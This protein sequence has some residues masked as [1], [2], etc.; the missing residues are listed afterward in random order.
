MENLKQTAKY[1]NQAIRVCTAEATKQG[2]VVY[3][4]MIGAWGS[5][6]NPVVEVALQV[7]DVTDTKEKYD[8]VWITLHYYPAT[9][10]AK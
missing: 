9:K 7:R 2:K 3:M 8:L 4:A 6:T 1:F 10:E 5:G